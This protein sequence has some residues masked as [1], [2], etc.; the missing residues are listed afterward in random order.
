MIKI[1]G[2]YISDD[3][4]KLWHT[5]TYI[6]KINEKV[7]TEANGMYDEQVK[8]NFNSYNFAFD[9]YENM[10]TKKW[11]KLSAGC[12][13]EVADAIYANMITQGFCI[14]RPPGHHAHASVASGFWFLNNVAI[15]ARHIQKNYDVKKIC[16]FD[17]DVHFGDGTAAIFESDPSV[18]FISIHKFMNGNFYPGPSGS[19]K[20]TGDGKGK[21]FNI[22]V[23]FDVNEMGNDEYIY[24]CENL[25]FPIIEEFKPE[26]L[27]I[28]AG[29]DSAEGDPLGQFK[30]TPSGYAYMTQRLLEICPKI[31]AVL[32]GG[33]D[34]KAIT[35]CS[36]AVVRVLKG[37]K[38]PIE[39][40]EANQS[41]EEMYM[42]SQPHKEAKR[43]V[44]SVA[45]YVHKKWDCVQQ[46]V[47][48]SRKATEE[49]AKLKHD[50]DK[51]NI[52]EMPPELVR[53]TTI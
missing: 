47:V 43:V 52:P 35:K 15:V 11:A 23:P 36:E 44:T 9:T 5:E 2:D 22:S 30:L 50:K 16:I 31:I 13:L 14:V 49:E 33:Y 34:L 26:I 7:G 53:K 51:I 32:E 3:V 1:D 10:F 25:V 17:W 8:R 27:L 20:R 4:I 37:Q 41:L 18:L 29:F 21:G 39:E 46:L 42:N 38:L 48:R 19:V 28:S 24:V 6:K 40:I 45:K 12:V